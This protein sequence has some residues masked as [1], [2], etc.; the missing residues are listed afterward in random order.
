MSLVPIVVRAWRAGLIGALALA[1]VAHGEPRASL[2]SPVNNSCQCASG[3]IAVSGTS[4]N[5]IAANYVGDRLEYTRDPGTGPWVT[6][7]TSSSPVLTSGFLYNWN[8]AG[9]PAGTYSLRLSV[10]GTDGVATAFTQVTLEPATLA[11][12]EI[13]LGDSGLPGTATFL[14]EVCF[15]VGKLAGC[16]G[17]ISPIVEFRPAGSG[18]FR[19]LST[20]DRAGYVEARLSL[21]G[22][23]PSLPAGAYEIRARASN[24]CGGSSQTSRTVTLYDLLDYGANVSLSGPSC[25]QFVT[26]IVPITGTINVPE[27][28]SWTLSYRNVATGARVQISS[29]NTNVNNGLIGSWDTRTLPPCAYVLELRG[30]SAQLF[31]CGG[32]QPAFATSR[33]V[34]VGCLAD[35]NRSGFVSVQDVFD[36]LGAFFS[37]CF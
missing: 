19:T 24:T 34:N 10:S 26:G 23:S 32:V 30:F 35:V 37:P 7:G 21:T 13:T 17:S 27:L 12:P 3:V 28:Q 15:R 25:G 6:V 9:L 33:A 2:T 29:G 36:F 1:S 4:F 20:I 5:T 16:Q 31:G 14:D 11:P 18:P 22:F 8:T